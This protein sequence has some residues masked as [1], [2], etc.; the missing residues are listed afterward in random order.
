[1]KTFTSLFVLLLSFG[2]INAGVSFWGTKQSDAPVSDWRQV[3]SHWYWVKSYDAWLEK[4]ACRLVDEFRVA[5]ALDPGNFEYW[6][7]AANKIAYDFPVWEIDVLAIKEESMIASI[8]ERYGRDAL[9]FFE[10][11]RSYFID[12]SGWY[13]AAGFLADRACDDQ[14]MALTYFQE[15]VSLP[16]ISYP[17]G[18]NYTRLLIETGRS[19]EAL[20]FL[21]TWYPRILESR[22]SERKA[23]IGDWISRLEAKTSQPD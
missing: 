6:Q 8:R 2:A 16:G 19:A 20:V 4:D 15:G 9:A 23:E 1:M 7:L 10:T 3:L 22:F 5:T 21:K 13:L 11:S 14:N 12:D 18:V 17:L